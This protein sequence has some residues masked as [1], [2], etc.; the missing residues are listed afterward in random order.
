MPNEP[1]SL[2]PPYMSWGVFKSTIDTLAESGVPSGPLDRRVLHGLSGA[3]HGAL[4]SG[5]RFLGLVDSLRHGTQRYRELVTASKNA[6]KFHEMLL[7]ILDAAYKS[8]LESV[9]LESGTIAQLEKAFKDQGVTQGQM[10]TKTI[11]FFIKAYTECGTKLSVHIT[12]PSPKAPRSKAEKGR[13]RGTSK[14]VE[15]TPIPP[16]TPAVETTPKG[17]SRLPI[18]GIANAFIQYPLD[19]TDAQCT[20]LD[21]AVAFL[22]VFATGKIGKGVTP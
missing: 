10:L 9:D 11:R 14:P 19:L 4:I 12:K 8:V 5:M 1:S 13:A 3:D 20:L 2:I 21:G 18:P 16:G 17:F 7:E 15:Q 6:D 22:K